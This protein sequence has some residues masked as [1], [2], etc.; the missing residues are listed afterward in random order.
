M[1]HFLFLIA[2]SAFPLAASVGPPTDYK[3]SIQALPDG[4]SYTDPKL[5]MTFTMHHRQSGSALPDG[6][7]GVL[8]TG[9]RFHVAL[10]GLA[11]DFSQR[12]PT[13]DGAFMTLHTVA[14]RTAEGIRFTATCTERSDHKLRS[15]FASSVVAAMLRDHPAGTKRPVEHGS[16]RGTHVSIRTANSRGEME[17]FVVGERAYQLIVEYPETEASYMPSLCERFF[18]SLTITGAA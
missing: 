3:S 14:L 7:Y 11:A 18:S 10:P 15:D 9:G 8:S 13:E 6:W 16:L 2:L 4:G 17:V 12:A 1:M 5:G